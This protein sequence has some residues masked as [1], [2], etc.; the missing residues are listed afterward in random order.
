MTPYEHLLAKSEEIGWPAHHKNDL[1]GHDKEALDGCPDTM[2]FMWF[3]REC[4]TW[5]ITPNGVGFSRYEGDG[6]LK[7][8]TSPYG[9]KHCCFLW[10]G[11]KL[12]EIEPEQ[13]NRTFDT[14][15]VS[16]HLPKHTVVVNT[17]WR[18]SPWALP[19]KDKKVYSVSWCKGQDAL[20]DYIA[21]HLPQHKEHTIEIFNQTNEQEVSA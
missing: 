10:S 6:L 9:T 14:F 5:L 8:L 11:G 3:V 18:H 12:R 19:Q 4:G 1:T 2:P 13:F 16:N 7:S 17:I 15:I 20:R 21:S